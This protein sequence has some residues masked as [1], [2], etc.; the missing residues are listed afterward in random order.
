MYSTIDLGEIMTEQRYTKLSQKYWYRDNRTGKKRYKRTARS[1]FGETKQIWANDYSNWGSKKDNWIEQITREHET[2]LSS[3]ELTA[4]EKITVGELSKEWLE[5]ISPRRVKVGTVERRTTSYN[6]YVSNSPLDRAPIVELTTK[7]M[8]RYFNSLDNVEAMRRAKDY[9]NPLFNYAKDE[10]EIITVNPIPNNVLA[11]ITSETNLKKA[12]KM[13]S[14]EDIVF[15]DE[16]MRFIYQA[17]TEYSARTGK[18][19]HIPIALMM[20]GGMRVSEAL[21][22]QISNIDLK[23]G[24]LSVNNQTKRVN[25][26]IHGVSK[27]LV[28]PK[29]KNSTRTYP[30]PYEVRQIILDGR[31]SKKDDFLFTQKDGNFAVKNAFT[32]GT[33]IPFLQEAGVYDKFQEQPNHLFRKYYGSKMILEN[34]PLHVVAK[35][36]GT[37]YEVLKTTYAKEI[38]AVEKSYYNSDVG[39]TSGVTSPIYGGQK[40]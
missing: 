15:D 24:T 35:W 31:Y 8:K 4:L 17:A 21:A 27:M 23:N 9:L 5:D 33:M 38:A 40:V 37:S 22:T 14:S 20:H 18:N 28:P 32:K 19:V 16:E 30:L 39:V 11:A 34:I 26:K 29:T 12:N 25:K 7:H 3:A 2:G 36:M 6:S 1:P 13:A 10:L